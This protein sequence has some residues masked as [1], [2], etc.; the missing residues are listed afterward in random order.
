MPEQVLPQQPETVDDLLAAVR[1]LRPL[2]LE[3]SAHA[4]EQRALADPV[5]D[6]ML[7]AGLFRALVPKAYGGLELHPTEAY[8]IFEELARI[9]SA[10]AWCLQIS[11]AAGLLAVPWF[12]P[13]GVDELFADGPDTIFAGSFFPPG[14]ALR[15]DGGWRVTARTPIA[16]GCQRASGSFCRS[17]RFRRRAVS[18]IP[19]RRILRP[20][21]SWFHATRSTSST[22][23][24]PWGCE[25]PSA[26]T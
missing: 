5:Y 23:G 9:D 13:E 12:P 3:H 22:P 2:I 10:A 18:S 24:T 1:R 6:A 7:E 21:R 8:R 4:E 15:V 17:S 25:A 16:S 11:L 26:G 20:L 14:P 19:R